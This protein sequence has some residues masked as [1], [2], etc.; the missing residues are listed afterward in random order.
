VVEQIVQEKSD[1]RSKF[2]ESIESKHGEPV[3]VWLDRL[4]ASGETS[5]PAQIALLRDQ[6]GFSRTHANAVVM[7]FRG[8]TT[9]KRFDG[10]D[11]YF[12]SVGMV[13]SATMRKIFAEVVAIRPDLN[14]VVAWN[15]PI[16][17]TATSYVFGV[18]AAKAHLTINPFSAAA[19]AT[20]GQLLKGLVVNK[21]TFHVPVDWE[22]NAE[23]VHVLVRTRLAEIDAT[24]IEG[25]T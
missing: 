20:A 12:E 18:S 14:V 8:S 15:Q 2:F 17:R 16:V 21:H 19:L 11:S 9:S 22:V 25:A 5:Y 3:Q 24:E 7:W 6:H 1:E 10:P 4:S 23:L 13:K